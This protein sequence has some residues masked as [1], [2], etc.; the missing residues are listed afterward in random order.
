MK[1]PLLIAEGWGDL[2]WNLAKQSQQGKIV[3]VLDEISWMGSKDPTFIG[4]L[5]TAR[6]L[7]FKNNPQLV[8]IL[9]KSISS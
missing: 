7:Y 4:K 3:I 2:F 1:I 8:L 5:K 6:D 9:C